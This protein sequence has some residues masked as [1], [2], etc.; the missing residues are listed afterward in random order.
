MSSSISVF[1]M[2]DFRLLQEFAE[3]QSLRVDSCPTWKTLQFD[4]FVSSKLSLL[5][6]LIVKYRNV[7]LE[8]FLFLTRLYTVVI[9]FQALRD[10]VSSC[11]WCSS[12]EICRALNNNRL[13]G[14]IPSALGALT[15]LTWFD[16]AYNK[17]SGPLPVSTTST[18][19]L[20]IDSWTEIQH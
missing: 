4:L 19:G 5:G 7:C 14:P 17:L 20:G 18:D 16:V 15:K 8:N 11:K 9:P 13:S 6:Y 3:M 12:G 2:W 1:W 10:I